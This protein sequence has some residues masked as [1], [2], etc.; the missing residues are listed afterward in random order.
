MNENIEEKQQE[1]HDLIT[2][3][4]GIHVSKI[5]ELLKMKITEVEHHLN[6]LEK[7]GKI[8]SSQE[9]GYKRYYIKEEG[10]YKSRKQRKSETRKE[11]YTLIAQRPGI[12]LT[13][14]AE[15]LDMSLQLAQ[16][17]LSYM[18]RN[19]E[20]T[21][22]KKPGAYHKRYYII[23]SKI[24]T[25]EKTILEIL[26]KNLSLEI[27]LLLLKHH[28][29]RHKNIIDNLGLSPSR[30]SY[31]LTRLIEKG[32]INVQHHGKEKG[33][34]LNH[35]DEIIRILKKYRIKIES[36]LAIEEFLEIWDDLYDDN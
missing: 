28:Q 12:Y 7:K 35:K 23:D 30:L 18:E 20:I 6:N 36:E 17:H 21:V 14:I 32:I 3:L 19:K 33:I 1:I 2:R 26:G 27:I 11:I 22:E 25:Q 13:K 34:V 10:R 9:S 15:T 29:L 16:Y 24:G 5:S 31:H 4:H 8:Y